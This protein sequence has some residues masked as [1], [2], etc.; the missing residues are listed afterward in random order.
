[1]PKK[2][3]F[4]DQALSRFQHGV[5]SLLFAIAGLWLLDVANLNAQQPIDSQ[6]TQPNIVLIMAD[7]LGWKDLRCYGNKNLETPNLDRLA[8]QG[9]LFTNP[10][11]ASPVC[12]PTPA[13]TPLA[14]AGAP[15]CCGAKSPRACATR[16][17]LVALVPETACAR[18]ATAPAATPA[19]GCS[20]TTSRRPP[21]RA[22]S[23]RTGTA[24]PAARRRGTGHSNPSDL[25]RS[26]SKRKCLRPCRTSSIRDV[27]LKA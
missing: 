1:M 9:V 17:A 20:T 24:A 26:S 14:P 2:H 15:P 4:N 5:A 16:S 21:R 10:S 22:T 19:G 12:T 6:D 13:P 7:D 3:I 18:A 23:T 27:K 11:S 8:K 25:Q